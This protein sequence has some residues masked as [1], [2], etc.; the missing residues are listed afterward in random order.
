MSDLTDYGQISVI[1]PVFNIEN[2]IEKCVNSIVKQTYTK[3]EIIL[4]DDGSTDCSGMLCDEWEE[5]DKRIRVIHKKNGGLS[6]AR[7]AGIDIANGD[8]LV[9]IDGDDYVHKKMVE[10]LYQNLINTKSDI[11]VCKYIKINE[12]ELPDISEK[13][14]KYQTF[15]GTE[16]NLQLY[17]NNA[18]CCVMWNKMFSKKLFRTLRFPV[19]KVHED[20]FVIHRLL[21]DADKIVF[22]N[23][24]LYYYIQ[25]KGS[26]M[27]DTDIV[28]QKKGRDDIWQAYCEREKFYESEEKYSQELLE[29]RVSMLFTALR[30]QEEI[31][32]DG[33]V[34]ISKKLYR[35][36]MKRMLKI[37]EVRRKI[38]FMN[39][40]CL[41][42]HLFTEKF[43]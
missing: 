35:N 14:I 22:C 39:T 17:R 30:L 9:F 24:I 18:E 7:N 19:G 5:R 33:A 8:F 3:L 42:I 13:E 21:A 2:Y 41:C 1:I 32:Y 34:D 25:R 27:N 31:N 40:I 4:V 16:K 6:D 37:S 15:M 38:G 28:R 20:E 29:T 36:E 10:V 43:N 23:Q 12:S 26:I 11:S